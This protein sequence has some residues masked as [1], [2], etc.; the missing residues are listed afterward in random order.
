VPQEAFPLLLGLSAAFRLEDVLLCQQLSR[1]SEREAQREVM[2]SELNHRHE[3]RDAPTPRVTAEND[4]P[5]NKAAAQG[6][7][8]PEGPS[9]LVGIDLGHS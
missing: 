8:A 1:C 9:T 5:A 2:R 7:G 6:R 3:V 4:D